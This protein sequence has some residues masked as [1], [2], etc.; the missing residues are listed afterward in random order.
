MSF[1]NDVDSNSNNVWDNTNIPKSGAYSSTAPK[2]TTLHKLEGTDFNDAITVATVLSSD[3]VLVKVRGS[4]GNDTII[5]ASNNFTR[6]QYDGSISEFKITP[7]YS[8]GTF[9]YYGEA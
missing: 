2:Y 7:N 1:S 3:N 5:G 6:L 9:K 8:G 4:K